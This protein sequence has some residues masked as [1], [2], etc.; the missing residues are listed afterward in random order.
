MGWRKERLIKAKKQLTEYGIIRTVALK[1]K[2][3]KSKGMVIK[4]WLIEI[5]PLLNAESI[6]SSVKTSEVPEPQRFPLLT[7][8]L[9]EPQFNIN[10]FNK[11]NTNKNDNKDITL[12][13]EH[14]HK[15]ITHF[16]S[17]FKEV[18]PTY[19]RLFRETPQ[20]EAIK[21]LLKK[22]GKEK[23]EKIIKSLKVSNSIPYAPVITTPIQLERKLGELIAFWEREKAKGPKVIEI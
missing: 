19:E 1:E 22:F 18:N 3:Q 23:L 15:E 5:L 13:E 21:R 17:L 11:C 14:N 4:K 7:S 2:S 16:I 9:R 6:I 12:L 10:N 20:K 8:E